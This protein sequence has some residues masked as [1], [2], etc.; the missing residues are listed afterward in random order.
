MAER[1]HTALNGEYQS[2]EE[3]QW[4]RPDGTDTWT[5]WTVFPWRDRDGQ[6]GASSSRSPH[7]DRKR[8]EFAL[9]ES[10][11]KFRMMAETVPD[12]LFMMDASGTIEYLNDKLYE[13]T[14]LRSTGNGGGWAA[15]HEDDR[16]RILP[17]GL[18]RPPSRPASL[19]RSARA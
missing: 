19:M 7:P 3:D 17:S 10:E 11:K 16:E 6:I 14:G 9:R 4:T 2:K 15:I 5:R 18:G 13:I 8:A 1:A 12:I